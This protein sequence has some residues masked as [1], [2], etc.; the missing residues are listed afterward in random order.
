MT[1]HY[2]DQVRKQLEEARQALKSAEDE[3]A[4]HRQRARQEDRLRAAWH[5]ARR[6]AAER[7]LPHP[8]AGALM[9]QVQQLGGQLKTAQ[10]ELVRLRQR[11]ADR[12]AFAER[13]R[14]AWK[15]TAGAPLICSDERHR[16]KVNALESR[17]AAA[18]AY[19]Q[20]LAADGPAWDGNEQAAGEE[21]L[22]LLDGTGTQPETCC[23]CGG[24]PVVYHNYRE[25]P[26]CCP[27]AECCPQPAPEPTP[28]VD[29]CHTVTVDGDTIRVR[30]AGTLGRVGEAA[31]VEV[32]R[33]AKRRYA[34]E[35]PEAP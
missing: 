28:V 14:A 22:R 7:R 1:D 20:K 34:T 3:L 16:A 8:S 29:T 5:S 19:A 10:A 21:I 15:D 33:A 9:A 27:C 18:R 2:H 35:H 31:L 11:D 12:D 4:V 13:L 32:I 26:F 23:I 24:G 6:R 25:Q 30:G 17:I